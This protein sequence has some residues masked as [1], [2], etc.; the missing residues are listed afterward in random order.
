MRVSIVNPRLSFPEIQVA[1]K[2]TVR[3]VS[4][5]PE[6]TDPEPIPIWKLEKVDI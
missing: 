2:W 1:D 4:S 6:S 3:L 5:D